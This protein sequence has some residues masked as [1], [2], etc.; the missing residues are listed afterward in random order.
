MILQKLTSLLKEPIFLYGIQNGI[1]ENHMNEEFQE[2]LLNLGDALQKF[3]DEDMQNELWRVHDVIQDAVRLTSRIA[4]DIS[5]ASDRVDDSAIEHDWMTIM[6][7][8]QDHVQRL[9]YLLT[10][11]NDLQISEKGVLCP[12]SQASHWKTDC[13]SEKGDRGLERCLTSLYQMITGENKDIKTKPI[14]DIFSQ[15]AAQDFSRGQSLKWCV[16]AFSHCLL[17]L[18]AAGTLALMTANNMAGNFDQLDS[19]QQTFQQRF[20]ECKR[21]MEQTIQAASPEFDTFTDCSNNMV[22]NVSPYTC[23]VPDMSWTPIMGARISIMDSKFLALE[24]T[25]MVCDNTEAVNSPPDV[26]NTQL[27][28]NEVN[29]PENIVT[30]YKA[31]HV[32]VNRVDDRWLRVSDP[33]HECICHVQIYA[34]NVAFKLKAAVGNRCKTDREPTWIENEGD[35]HKGQNPPIISRFLDDDASYVDSSDVMPTFPGWVTGIRLYQKNSELCGDSVLA[36]A[37]ETSYI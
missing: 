37:L 12:E 7:T 17:A 36:I 9:V 18:Q 28:T 33:A 20:E 14:V 8:Y 25:G 15:V 27:F 30:S 22:S 5:S 1:S 34:T 31:T 24:M 4:R 21:K 16:Q 32:T 26:K 35:Y 23:L 3:S 2:K 29:K 13:L 10:E 19:I 11:L 6:V